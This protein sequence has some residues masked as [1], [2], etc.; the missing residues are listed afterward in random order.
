MNIRTKLLW[1]SILPVILISFASLVV[2]N[3]QSEKLAK[4]QVEAVENLIR[5]SKEI[6]LGNYVRLARTA[7][8]P[9]YAS[10]GA[11]SEEAKARVAEIITQMTFGE[12][13]YFFVYEGDGTNV[14]HPKL[15]ELIGRNWIDLEDSQG[16]KV[17]KDLIALGKQGGS[18]YQYVWNKPSIDADVEKLGYSIYLDKWD[19]MLGS[20]LYLDDIS[21]QIG[22]IQLQLEDNVQQTRWVLLALATGAV[23]LTSLLFTAVRLS[24]QRFADER[25]KLLANR[26]V[27]TQ[28]NERKRVSTELHDGISQILVSARY[29]LDIAR[30]AADG[31]SRVLEPLDK[32]MNTISMAISEIRRISM[33]LRPSVLDDMGL[34]AAI[35]SLCDDFSEQ[36]GLKVHVRA[37]RVGSLLNDREKTTLYR[38]CQEAL[39]NVAKHAEAKTVWVELTTTSKLVELSVRDDGLGIRSGEPGRKEIG[40]GMRN[41]Q[42]RIDSH[43]GTFDLANSPEGGV[44]LRVSLFVDTNGKQTFSSHIPATDGVL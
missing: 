42:E 40:F 2:I 19:W 3:L 35:K 37:N 4:Q 25:L 17:I 13:G 8:E 11:D 28:E 43:K 18:F 36:T 1:I 34:S 10:Q 31:Q 44:A 12:D 24:E 22:S 5:R 21:A 16:N 6:E 14:V 41:I 23:L 26:I 7:I 30:S 32:A 29:G 9:I 20:G 15:P 33:A 38:V 39:A 27:D